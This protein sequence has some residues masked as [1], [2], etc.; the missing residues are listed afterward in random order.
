MHKNEPKVNST[1]IN[2]AIMV[3]ELRVGPLRPI[4]VLSPSETNYE[5]DSTFH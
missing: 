2:R 5:V 1:F 3:Y 4:G